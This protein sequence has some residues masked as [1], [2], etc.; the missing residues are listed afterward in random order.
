MPLKWIPCSKSGASKSRPRWAAHT[1]IGNVWEYPPPP[2][3]RSSLID[4]FIRT[5]DWVFVF[6]RSLVSIFIY[7]LISCRIK[8]YFFFSIANKSNLNNS[9]QKQ[10]FLLTACRLGCFGRRGICV[11]ATEILYW[12]HKSINLVVM[13][14][15]MQICLILCLFWSILV[16]FCIH[17]WMSSSKTQT[18]LLAKNIFYEYLLFRYRFIAF[19]FDLCG[20]LSFVCPS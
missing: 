7:M 15:Q 4:H 16:K 5:L 18:L 14:F 20:L 12:W 2:P 6:I 10:L 9:L 19:R 8:K 13:G 17:L 11:S 3:P 1:C